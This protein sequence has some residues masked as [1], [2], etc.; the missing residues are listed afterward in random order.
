M[1][2]PPL[3]PP[4]NALSA[5]ALPS[6]GFALFARD[7]CAI[8]FGGSGRFAQS[9]LLGCVCVCVCYNTP[10]ARTLGVVRGYHPRDGPNGEERIVSRVGF[11]AEVTKLK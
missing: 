6:L 4:L 1:K 9:D 11:G 7:G 3:C 2:C 8:R 5:R 10:D